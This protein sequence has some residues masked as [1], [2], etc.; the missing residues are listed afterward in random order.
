MSSLFI[1]MIGIEER[2][3][4]FFQLNNRS[5]VDNYLF[6]I[7]KEYSDD[8]RVVEYKSKIEEQLKGAD[9]DIIMT[10]YFNSL[11]LVRKFNE[12]IIK[13]SITL[14]QCKICLDISTFNRQNLLSILF[15]LRQKYGI[16]NVTCYYTIPED[17]NKSISKHA[18]KAATIPFFGGEQSI[19]RNKLLI[20]MV[21]FEYDRALYLWEKV[22]PAKTIITVGDKPTDSKY[23]ATNLKVIEE[24][25]KRIVNCEVVE[26]VSANDPF[27]ARN[28]LERII[29][30]YYDSYNIVISP[31]NTKLQTLG[32]YLAWEKYPE[33]QIAYTCPERFEDWLSKGIRETQSFEIGE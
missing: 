18:H 4:G 23:L 16:K 5:V 27:E 6:F 21:G 14:H 19:D 24:L 29:K 26:K 7:N 30:S 17:T 25:R 20:L 15:L 3:L 13:K 22:E 10:S 12:Y 33:I 2:V 28:D 11:E 8:P 9:M 31:M 1:S 32:L